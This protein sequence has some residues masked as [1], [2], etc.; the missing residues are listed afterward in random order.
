[1]GMAKSEIEFSA[2]QREKLSKLLC[3]A[4]SISTEAACFEDATYARQLKMEADYLIAN[5]V[6]FATDNNVGSKWIPVTERLPDNGEIVLA[7]GKRHATSG[8]FQGALRNN[9]KLWHWKGNTLKEVTHWMP[10]PEPPKGE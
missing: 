8:M 2:N 10:L 3:T 1:M 5:G 6:T 7:C 4:H 9:P